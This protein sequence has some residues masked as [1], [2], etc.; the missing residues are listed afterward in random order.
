MQ[1]NNEQKEINLLLVDNVLSEKNIFLFFIL[2]YVGDI[3]PYL[4]LSKDRTNFSSDL[5]FLTA[6]RIS[7]TDIIGKIIP[8]TETSD[9]CPANA[10]DPY[11]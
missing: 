2:A 7:T 11:E 8:F 1:K 6:N 9:K 5:I 3:R 10:P 4:I